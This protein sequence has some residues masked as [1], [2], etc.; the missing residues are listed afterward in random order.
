[1]S[2]DALPATM[3]GKPTLH[4]F[5][6]NGRGELAKLIAAV[7]GLEIDVVEYPRFRQMVHI[8]SRQVEGGQHGI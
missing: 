1:M 8:S 3:S 7:G 6:V 2:T 5:D 4:Y